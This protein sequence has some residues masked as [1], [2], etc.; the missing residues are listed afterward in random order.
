MIY[1]SAYGNSS[2]IA[3]Y[4]NYGNINGSIEDWPMNVQVEKG[5]SS[6]TV[7]IAR[8]SGSTAINFYCTTLY[9]L[10]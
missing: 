10:K 6:D 3:H 4:S 1:P 9:T 7:K 2:W 5:S 8:Y